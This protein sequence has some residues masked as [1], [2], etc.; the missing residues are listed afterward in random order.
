MERSFALGFVIAFPLLSS[1]LVGLGAPGLRR[2]LGDD[3]GK[4]GAVYLSLFGSSMA[5]FFLAQALFGALTD[6][7]IPSLVHELP[8]WLMGE[9]V[10]VSGRLVLDPLSGVFAL[11]VA[12]VGT[13]VQIFAVGWAGERDDGHRVFAWIGALEAALLLLILAGSA[14]LVVLAWAGI[15]LLG[16]V[17]IG[18]SPNTRARVAAR[19]HLPFEALSVAALL[20]GLVSLFALV[21]VFDFE[22]MRLAAASGAH[23]AYREVAAFGLPLAEVAAGA[24]GLALALRVG[25]LPFHA[26]VEASAHAPLP[27]LGLMQGA[28]LLGAT[29]LVVRLESLFALAPTA[30]AMMTALGLAS[31]V[32]GAFVALGEDRI[33]R[34]STYSSISQ[35][36]LV[37]AA[38][39]MGA[40][41][42]GIALALAH[43]VGKVGLTLACAAAD[44]S[45]GTI[46]GTRGHARAVSQA[47]FW[48]CACLAGLAPTAGF[49]ALQDVALHVLVDVSAFSVGINYV[50]FVAC[51]AAAVAHV[52]ALF[53]L[54]YR[55]FARPSE[56]REERAEDG[57]FAFAT[58]FLAVL[59]VGLGLAW[60]PDLT[61][62]T[63]LLE[64]WISPQTRI[65]LG[66]GRADEAFAL[67][68]SAAWV[69]QAG[70]G[71]PAHVQWAA[72]LSVL[73][74]TTGTWMRGRTAWIRGATRAAGALGDAVALA[75]RVVALEQGLW[76]AISRLGDALSTIAHFGVDDVVADRGAA[77]TGRLGDELGRGVSRLGIGSG[78]RAVVAMLLGAAFVL[79]WIY[80]KPSIAGFGPTSVHDFGGLR[81]GLVRPAQDRAPGGPSTG[82]ADA[83]EEPAA[84]SAPGDDPEGEGG[85]RP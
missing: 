7:R 39:G 23:G 67:G 20:L 17:A 57:A 84:A 48:S 41:S 81:P 11:T 55:V 18:A 70:G 45:D 54:H 74:A 13:L 51:L 3:R 68:P 12:V 43:A 66:L 77:I 62:Q 25:L 33:D 16:H 73:A 46:T 21:P 22:S 30:M 58:V 40:W 42:V 71:L 80:F 5:V 63:N 38:L 52:A 9:V 14:A 72:L 19:R 36:G 4:V 2:W 76:K 47:A 24:I 34:V 85:D 59:A 69:E 64:D 32:I 8:P 75:R 44:E 1:L 27:Q 65:G 29:Y 79:G 83:S 82:S 35:A 37:F 6:A 60:A 61:W 53:R 15:G 50:G 78:R 56:V 10:A 26:G 31:A 49:F 28:G